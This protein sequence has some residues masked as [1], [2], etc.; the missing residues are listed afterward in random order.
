[1]PKFR[2]QK[3]IVQFMHVKELS[4]CFLDTNHP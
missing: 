4:I 1:V 3:P 2:V